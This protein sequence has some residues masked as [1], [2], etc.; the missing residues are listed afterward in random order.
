NPNTAT[1]QNLGVNA[2]CGAIT[3]TAPSPLVRTVCGLRSIRPGV[4][5]TVLNVVGDQYMLNFGGVEGNVASGGGAAANPFSTMQSL[6]PVIL[7]QGHSA[8]IYIWFPV[9]SAP[10][11]ATFAPEI[12]FWVR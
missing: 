1:P 10:S 6:P 5:T 3:A 11:A 8:L 12:G 7:G 9:M 4:S 2:W